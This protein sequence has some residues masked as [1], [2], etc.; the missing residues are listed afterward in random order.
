MNPGSSDDGNN[1]NQHEIRDGAAPLNCM[2]SNEPQYL[3]TP[4]A[5][6]QC[7][8]KVKNYVPNDYLV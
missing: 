3:D 5:A 7:F 4:A 6:E 8:A 1:E 2:L